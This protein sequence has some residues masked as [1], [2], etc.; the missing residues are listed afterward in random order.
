MAEFFSR[1]EIWIIVIY[2][3][4]MLVIAFFVS[5]SSRNVE[6]YTVGNRR[7]PGWALGLSVLGTFTSSISFL[8]YP[9]KAYA[10]NWNAFVFGLALP[11]AAYLAVRW[12]VPL[13][14][15]G[16]GFSAY[17]LLEHRFGFWARVYAD[18]SFIALQLIRIATVLLL[19]AFAMSEMIQWEVVPTVIGLGLLVIIYD[20]LGGIQ[21]VI[22]TDVVQV[23]VLIGGALWC[24]A[25]LVAGAGGLEVV[26]RE[27][28]TVK[29]EFGP[30]L[31]AGDDPVPFWSLA[32]PTVL[33]ILIYGL[34]ENLRNY[35]VDQNYVQRMLAAESD[36]EASRSLWIGA[37]GYLP[38]SVIFF[39]IG[40][41]LYMTHPPESLAA[42]VRADQVFPNF[43]TQQLPAPV[44]GLVLAAV[45]AA[46]MST[47][48]SSLNA[49]S[50]VVLVDLLRPL[51]RDR[52]PLWPEIISLRVSTVTL[53]VLGTGT[54]VVIY[55]IFQ[56]EKSRTMLDLWWEYAGVAGGGMFGLFLLAW[57]LPKLPS[58]GA[59]LGVVLS[60]PVLAWGTFAREA[61]HGAWWAA[62]QCPLD[63]KLVGVSGTL[64]LLLV[65]LAVMSGV[66]SGLFR[67]N[68]R[69][70]PSE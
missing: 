10:T 60:F 44:A 68:P 61:P 11:P 46:A 9:A 52:K 42:G 40:T 67:P 22:W 32:S 14:R 58:W 41:V 47:V 19:V 17:E 57:L 28:P 69:S 38:L 4:S 1:I 66:R 36:R 55:S 18:V 48:D 21:A 31:G 26:L 16:V 56:A 37:L 2:M 7:I 53:G 45:L 24:L 33:V 29:L 8:A 70:L 12:F 15:R 13:Y 63:R 27:V 49:M 30:W 54:A 20:T 64:V 43:I 25:T 5:G 34:A 6:G 39:S 65:G 59:V 50:T 51:R 23:V 35:G 3:V 62:Y